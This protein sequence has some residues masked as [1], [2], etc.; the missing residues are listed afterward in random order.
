[1]ISIDLTSI[2]INLVWS[3]LSTNC[4]MYQGV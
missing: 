3:C 2:F 1:M 4:G